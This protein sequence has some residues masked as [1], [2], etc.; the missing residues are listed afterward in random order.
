MNTYCATALL[1]VL[2]L[3]SLAACHRNDAQAPRD[4]GNTAATPDAPQTII[5]KSVDRALREARRNLETGNLSLNEGVDIQMGEHGRRFRIGGDKQ[6]TPAA[7]TPQGGFLVQGKPVE[8]T[9]AQ[10]QLLLAYRRDVIGVAEAG[11]AV[12]VKGADLAGKAV[13]E[14]L[15]GLMQGNSGQVEQRM[16]A[17]GEKLQAEAM[18][19]CKLLPAMLSSQQ[20]LAAS[21]PEFRPYAKM[22]KDDIDECDAE[23]RKSMAGKPGAAVFSDADREQVRTDIWDG[24]RDAV[25][26]GAR[27]AAERESN[28]ETETVRDTR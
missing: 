13:M 20:K 8:V 9:P 17:E 27:T 22:T 10:R 15:N 12:G 3:P 14:T 16:H 5:G 19:I 28:A 7:I 23:I 6:D 24:V 11:M 1:L 26:E 18:K 21:L 2:A 4:A 25:R